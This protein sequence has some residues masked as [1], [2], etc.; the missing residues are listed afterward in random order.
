LSEKKAP[1]SDVFVLVHWTPV[2]ALPS[3]ATQP[4]KADPAHPARQIPIEV[5]QV[6][7][8][9]GHPMG[10]RRSDGHLIAFADFTA[11]SLPEAHYEWK[12]LR[13]PDN[14]SEQIKQT[15]GTTLCVVAFVAIV[16]VVLWCVHVDR[17]SLL[18]D[19][20]NNCN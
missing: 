15:V 13:K 9:R 17:H 10:F 18:D 2:A 19:L 7:V 14:S 5:Q 3:R 8:P 16:G 1:A 12:T 11:Q 20:F 6:Y 4:V